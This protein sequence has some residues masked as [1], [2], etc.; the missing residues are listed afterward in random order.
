[1]KLIQ[2]GN[3]IINLEQITSAEYSPDESH[4]SYPA[5]LYS[6]LRVNFAS[7][8]FNYNIFYEAEA[9]ALWKI[10]QINS[11][12]NLRSGNLAAISAVESQDD[13]TTPFAG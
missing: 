5:K 3:R 12:V 10:I 6:E 8:S 11:T 4:P 2:I 13:I 9:D 7:D 1:M